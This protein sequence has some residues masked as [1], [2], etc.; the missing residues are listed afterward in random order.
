MTGRRKPPASV[1]SLQTTRGSGF[2][3]P[4]WPAKSTCLPRPSISSGPPAAFQTD[5]WPS[6]ALYPHPT[7]CSRGPGRPRADLL[8]KLELGKRQASP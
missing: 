7:P 8:S 1:L 5:F 2:P 6:P 3:P 4:A